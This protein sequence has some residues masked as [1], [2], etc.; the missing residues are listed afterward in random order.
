MWAC[1]PGLSQQICLASEEEIHRWQHWWKSVLPD[2]LCLLPTWSKTSTFHAEAAHSHRWLPSHHQRYPRGQFPTTLL[3]GFVSFL[4]IHLERCQISYWWLV[5]G[6]SFMQWMNEWQE[7]MHGDLRIST[8]SFKMLMLV[9]N[10]LLF[11]QNRSHLEFPS[12]PFSNLVQERCKEACTKMSVS[13]QRC[14][15]GF[16]YKQSF[17]MESILNN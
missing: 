15:C 2:H 7:D 1:E 13:N 14:F 16:G 6:K 4:T 11:H 3:F 5:C 12:M 17:D 8:A 10:F 9:D